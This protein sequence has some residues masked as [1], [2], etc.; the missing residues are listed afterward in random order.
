VSPERDRPLSEWAKLA[1]CANRWMV[2]APA[3][4]PICGYN[5]GCWQAPD[6]FCADGGCGEMVEQGTCRGARCG[7]GGR[8]AGG[9]LGS[10]AAGAVYDSYHWTGICVL[11]GALGLATVA[12]ALYD[13]LPARPAAGF[14][15]RGEQSVIATCSV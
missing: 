11:G 6:S 3:V 4:G 2:A 7:A 9:A 1:R 10:A 8:G 12:I 14:A 5:V 15:A 13:H